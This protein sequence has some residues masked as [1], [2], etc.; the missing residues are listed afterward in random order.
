MSLVAFR[1]TFGVLLRNK[2]G[3]SAMSTKLTL[4]DGREEDQYRE[5]ILKFLENS[6]DAFAEEFFTV[7]IV[8]EGDGAVVN[9]TPARHVEP[10]RKGDPQHIA[11]QVASVVI[12]ESEN[13]TQRTHHLETI[14]NVKFG[15]PNS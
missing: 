10:S 8:E 3:G 1:A 2:G 14:I 11:E 13:R 15:L 4:A 6:P 5:E 12:Y 9:V 7:S